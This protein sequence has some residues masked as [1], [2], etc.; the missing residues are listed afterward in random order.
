MRRLLPVLSLALWSAACA[1]SEAPR[2]TPTVAPA[3]E[4]ASL[5][6]KLGKYPNQ[7]KFLEEAPLAARLK[8]LL[9]AKYASLLTNM[10]TAN[11]LSEEKGVFYVLGNKPHDS[12]TDGAAVVA[13]P[14]QDALYVW[15]LVKGKAE[16]FKEKGK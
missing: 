12:G 10:G 8:A 15:L 2:P 7:D 11:Q 9:G 4:L 5:S 13:D 6:Q 14:K 1:T 3:S 16:E